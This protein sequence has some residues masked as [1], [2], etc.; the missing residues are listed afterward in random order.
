VEIYVLCAK[1]GLG[2]V[3]TYAELASHV[4]TGHRDYVGN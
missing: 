4:E 3:P 1:C 2:I